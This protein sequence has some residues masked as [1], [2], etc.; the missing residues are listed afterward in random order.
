MPGFLPPIRLLFPN[1]DVN[2]DSGVAGCSVV[3]ATVDTVSEAS[4][5]SWWFSST[6]FSSS[7]GSSLVNSTAWPGLGRLGNN[8]FTPGLRFVGWAKGAVCGWAFAFSATRNL[9]RF[10]NLVRAS[11]AAVVPSAGC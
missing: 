10:R 7:A 9:G 4:G 3:D 2:F 8:P 6:G 1:N 11:G 5:S